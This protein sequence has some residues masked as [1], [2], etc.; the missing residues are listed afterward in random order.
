MRKFWLVFAQSTTIAL[1]VLFVV[2]IFRSDWLTWRNVNNGPGITIR[3][4]AAPSSGGAQ[5]DSLS[6]AAKKAIPSVVNVFTSKEVRLP[7]NP[8]ADDPVFKRFFG[9]HPTSRSQRVNN[10]G[11]GV[12][13]SSDGYILTNHHV[14]EAADEIQVALHDG[15][16]VLAKVVGSD[17]ET[18][19][20]VLKV[21]L[22]GLP[23]ISFAQPDK[24]N[25]GD[26]VLAIGDPFGVGQTVTMGIISALERT[27][28]G[29]NTFENFIQTDA[30]I[31]PG[32]S[33]GAL[34]NA[35]GNLIGINSAIYTRTGGSQGIGFAI[36]VSLVVQIMDQIIKHGSVTRG[37]IGVEVQDL[38][39]E[40]AESF[41]LPS[42]DGALIAGIL[43]GGPADL[44]GIKP[45]DVLIDVNGKPVKDSTSLLQ[46]IAAQTPGQTAQLKLL[47][48]TKEIVATVNINKRPKIEQPVDDEQ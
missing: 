30:A 38:T 27:H 16:T 21:N 28:L 48:K 41:K 19:L 34:V 26:F 35:Q 37:W 36:P 33:G 20:A 22:T 25:V 9:D 10:L 13:V 44:A 11:S 3:E 4:V 8:L 24:G 17:P 14:V 43:K 6:A 46:L 29:I 1:G 12:I 32:N 42:T 23:A 2:V 18:D 39:P 15:R 40:L 45:G 31:N 7:R 5:I 47:R